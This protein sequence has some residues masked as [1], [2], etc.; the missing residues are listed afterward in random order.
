MFA[1]VEKVSVVILSFIYNE[2]TRSWIANCQFVSLWNLKRKLGI[3][4][5]AQEGDVELSIAE[6]GK[7]VS[8]PVGDML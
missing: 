7:E 4:T 6:A 3:W 2:K 8:E 5:N 1:A